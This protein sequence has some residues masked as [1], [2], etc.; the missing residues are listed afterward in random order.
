MLNVALLKNCV[1]F[2]LKIQSFGNRRKGELS[3]EA[4]QEIIGRAQPGQSVPERE[5]QIADAKKRL[6]LGKAL[7]QSVELDKIKEFQKQVA[8]NLLTRYCNRSFIDE[9]LYAV[10]ADVV[11]KVETEIRTAI[12][13]LQNEFVPAFVAVYDSR[14]EEARKVFN[15]QFREKDYP[16]PGALPGLFGFTY[17]WVKLDVPE[18][19]PPEIRE[20]EEKKLRD[21]YAQA[22]EAIQGAL[23]SEFDKFLSHVTDR[24]EPG[25]DGKRKT[26][27]DTLFDDLTEFVDAFNNRNAFNDEKLGALVA[28][29]KAAIASAGGKTPAEAAV[30]M[31]DF[32]TLRDK[33]A[34]AFAKVKEEVT[35]II[36]ENA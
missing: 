36:A 6:K 1:L 31:R 13:R 9:G 12:E 20:Q 11:P 27:R 26:F 19:L 35:K 7:V 21:T 2:R 4:V 34:A 15:G 5:K 22:Q 33:T 14:V 29:A 23:W 3:D 25:P 24:L 32:E 16:K 17:R 28:Q 30:A 8:S 10:K 18:G